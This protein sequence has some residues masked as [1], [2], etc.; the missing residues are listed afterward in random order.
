MSER[1]DGGYAYQIGSRVKVVREEAPAP[2]G[3]VGKV[4]LTNGYLIPVRHTI[5]TDDGR[6]LTGL[7]LDDLAPESP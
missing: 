1:Q 6:M 4:V 2:L 7:H 3:S 5:Q